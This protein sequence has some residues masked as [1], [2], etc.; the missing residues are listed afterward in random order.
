MAKAKILRLSIYLSIGTIA[1][2]AAT[3]AQD[4]KNNP[5]SYVGFMAGLASETVVLRHYERRKQ[6]EIAET[7]EMLDYLKGN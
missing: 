6:Q 2:L 3:R 4:W 5:D 1:V 7:S